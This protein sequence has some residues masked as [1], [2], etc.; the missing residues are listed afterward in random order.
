M[1]R[2]RIFFLLVVIF[3]LIVLEPLWFPVLTGMTLAFLCEG[4]TE[5]L[6]A[7]WHLKRPIYR[8]LVAIGVVAIVQGLF[9]VPLLLLT[10]TA[11]TELLAFWEGMNGDSTAVETGYKVLSWMDTTITPHLK[12]FG[13][14]LSFADM[15]GRLREFMQPALKSVAGYLGSALSATPELLMF[16]FITWMAW[17]YFLIHGRQQRQELLPRLIPWTEQREIIGSTLAEVL[18]ATFLAS[19]VLSLVQSLMVVITLA[20]AGVPK[21]YLWGSLAFFMS[22]IPIFGTAPVMISAAVWCFYGDKSLAGIAILIMAVVI[23]GAD[24]VLR[25]L[26]MKGEKYEMNFFWLFLALI[27]GIAMFGIAGA[28][29][30]PWAFSLYI[31]IRSQPLIQ[32]KE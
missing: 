4:P 29:L 32:L 26:L 24:N 27:G 7:R 3:C 9:I 12:S 11:T 10:W 30:G 5:R 1:S 19:I 25:P 31:A 2:R 8:L 22:F 6:M 21:F 20:A 17:V 28:V 18:R 15:Q 13:F 23:G 14:H 16:L